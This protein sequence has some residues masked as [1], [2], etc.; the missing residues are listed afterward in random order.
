LLLG[1]GTMG[2]LTARQLLAQGVGSVM[3][4][5]RTFDRAIDVAR[6][7]SAMPVP[8]DRLARY[9]PL[10]DL[11]IA[12]ASGEEFLL[13]RPAVEA[14]MR[15]PRRR[16]HHRRAA[17]AG[18]GDPP[19][20]GRAQPGGAR[21]ARPAAARDDRAPDAGD[22]QQGPAR[23][24]HGPPPPPRRPGRGVLRRGGAPPLPS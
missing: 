7:L 18:G 23:P 6:A 16:A 24:A 22:R 2:E 10:A 21:P 11:V 14:A 1:A 15:E 17:R 19:V 20:R 8:W 4:A 3:V 12:A 5:N 13:Q 9:L